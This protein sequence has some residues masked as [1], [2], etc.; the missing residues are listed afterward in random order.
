MGETQSW[1][2]RLNGT[3]KG[4]LAAA[5]FIAAGAATYATASDILRTPEK[6]DEAMARVDSL[7]AVHTED[8]Q[9]LERGIRYLVCREEFKD[10]GLD[11]Q[12][13]KQRVQGLGE[14][15]RSVMRPQDGGR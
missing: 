8:R 4:V 14:M 11:P 12:L 2:E 5:F 9:M 6:V 3:R 13:C 15:L 7:A 1:W 10:R